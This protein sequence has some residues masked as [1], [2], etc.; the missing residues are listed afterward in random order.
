MR[1][2]QGYSLRA[3]AD[4]VGMAYPALFRLERGEADPRLSSLRRLAKAHKGPVAALLGGRHMRRKSTLKEGPIYRGYRLYTSRLLSEHWLCK[5]VKLGKEKVTTK[6]SLTAKVIGLPGEYA[7]EA[8]ALQA[9]K[10][11][12]DEEDARR[13]D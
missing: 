8:E 7:S 11:Y 2:A 1:V 6:D 9:A 4:K 10:R 3:L 5:I 12:I 13:Q